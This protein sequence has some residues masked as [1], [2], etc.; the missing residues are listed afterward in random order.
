MNKGREDPISQLRE[1]FGDIIK[2]LRIELTE[3]RSIAVAALKKVDGLEHEL[4]ERDD[5]LFKFFRGNLLIALIKK[6]LPEE[7]NNAASRS[8]KIKWTTL[9]ENC[10][11]D[12]FKKATRDYNVS[13]DSAQVMEIFKSFQSVCLVEI[14]KFSAVKSGVY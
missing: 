12:D 13:E 10:W 7:V 3:V 2:D 11:E 5:Y 6:L 4:R 14:P 8:T 1:D 9:A